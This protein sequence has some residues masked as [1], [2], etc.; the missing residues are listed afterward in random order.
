[1]E[2]KKYIV[3]CE[4][5]G[6]EFNISHEPQ[7]HMICIECFHKGNPPM[8]DGVYRIEKDRLIRS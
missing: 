2:E 7:L 5:C 6:K 4:S 1:M 8:Y 3:R